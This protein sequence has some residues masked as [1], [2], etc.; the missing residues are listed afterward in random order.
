LRPGRYGPHATYCR[1]DVE[2]T[3]R[4]LDLVRPPSLGPFAPVAAEVGYRD[5][6]GSSGATAGSARPEPDDLGEGIVD[7]PGGEV[8]GEKMGA[9]LVFLLAPLKMVE[10]KKTEKMMAKIEAIWAEWILP[11]MMSR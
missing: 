1:W 3:R 5:R 9:I 7:H 2:A 8:I 11:R 4:T 6:P 10:G